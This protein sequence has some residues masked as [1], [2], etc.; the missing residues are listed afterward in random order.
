M[1]PCPIHRWQYFSSF[2]SKSRFERLVPTF[3]FCPH[4]QILKRLVP[5]SHGSWLQNDNWFHGTRLYTATPST[6]S[7][8]LSIKYE[9]TGSSSSEFASLSSLASSEV[10]SNTAASFFHLR[11]K[12]DHF[13][14]N[15]TWPLHKSTRL[16]R[17][18]RMYPE[19][20]FS[21]HQY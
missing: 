17:Q 11:L 4:F 6:L 9:S 10:V 15:S 7:P 18:Y 1:Y 13:D 20:W 2:E 3:S 16:P 21:L 14:P 5:N 12:I 8:A 19:S